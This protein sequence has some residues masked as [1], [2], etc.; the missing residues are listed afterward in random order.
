MRSLFRRKASPLRDAIRLLALGLSG[1]LVGLPSADGAEVNL[2]RPA[3]CSHQLTLTLSPATHELR[4][5]DRM[6]LIRSAAGPGSLTFS[7]HPQLRV[8][9]VVQQL[10]DRPSPLVVRTDA[11]QDPETNEPVQWV[12]LQLPDEAGPTLVLEWTYEGMI[13]DPPK[14]AR[15]LRFVTPSETAGHI[16]PEGV[17]LSGETRW[18]PDLAGA[19]P[20]FRVSVTTPKGWEAVT[21]GRQLSHREDQDGV[22]T[23][24]D[25][26]TRTEALTL[27]ANRFVTTRR[28]WKGIELVTYLFPDDAALANEYLDAAARYLEAY[29]ARLGPY[30]FPKFA[31]V[32]NFFASGLG[33]PSFTLLGNGVIKRHYTQ[34]YALGHEIVHSW[35]GNS[36]FNDPAQGNWV[37]G[38]TTYLAN[39]YYEELTGT[40]E[41][42]KE[43]RRMMLRGYAVYVRSE[44]DYPVAAFKRKVDQKDNAIGYQKAAM[45]FHMLRREIGDGSFW[46]GVRNLVASYS[47][48][49]ATWNEVEQ[50]FA[51][52]AD[53]DLRWFFAQWVQQ[54][55]APTVRATHVVQ[56][57]VAGSPGE[58]GTTRL[59]VTLTQPSPAF[60]LSV[61]VTLTLADQSRQSTSVRLESTRQT[62]ELSFPSRAVSL[63]VDP[64][65]EL[66]RRIP[67]TELPPMLN[68]YV[69]DPQ[70]VV[71][72]PSG[73]TAEEQRPF[74]ELA[75]VIESRS[76]GTVIQT[77]QAPVP[78]EG[79]LLLL[80]GPGGNHVVRQILEHCGSQVTVDRDRFTVGGRT[81]AEP[82][83]AL[84]VTCRRPDS[85]GSM[86]TLFYGLSPQALSK[87]ARLL[88]FYGWQSYV[89]FHDGAVIARGDFPTAQEG[90]EVLLDEQR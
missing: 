76:P 64:D 2:F 48:V 33:M 51:R 89:V 43:Q 44:E 77:D 63:S 73:G 46:T 7:L 20:T 59:R 68:L 31:V 79:S 1:L 26:A 65:F 10:G 83:M 85:P 41:Q 42:A 27:V 4:A 18:Y 52:A 13:K 55:G 35:I 23:E 86:A 75:K 14:E 9:Q 28:D 49:H 84:L 71:V 24:W 90:M 87:V 39:Y 25:V 19:L 29:T 11:A 12:T 15:H 56:D 40:P 80:G 30:P 67:R 61:P 57:D 5:T 62:F 58:Q 81:Y 34:P 50:A 21:H 32:E 78:V 8:R 6:D 53:K 72:L 74:V 22:T 36:V 70:R 66:F 16:G 17:Y 54:A 88:F 60:R 3:I 38:L 45:V 82:G 37:E 69:T 47:G